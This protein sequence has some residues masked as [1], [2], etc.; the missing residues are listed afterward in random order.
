MASPLL[1]KEIQVDGKV[2]R[3]M[4]YMSGLGFS[5]LYLNGIKA[6]DRLM[7]PEFVDYTYRVPYVAKDITAIL[8][9]GTNVIGVILG[10]G[11]YKEPLWICLTSRM[12]PGATSPNFSLMHILN[13]ADGTIRSSSLTD[14]GRAATGSLLFNSLRGGET[15]D[16]GE[17]RK[18]GCS[19]GMMTRTGK[20]PLF[21]MPLQAVLVAQQVPPAGSWR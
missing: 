9:K 11:Y 20:M 12:L 14:A 13:T 2:K 21:W 6:D 10:G 7:D 15:C 17:Q 19:P 8:E 4:V 3:A 1:R 5:E 16:S 18:T